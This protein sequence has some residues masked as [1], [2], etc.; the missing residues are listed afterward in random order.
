MNMKQDFL[1]IDGYTNDFV[2]EVFNRTERHQP[3]DSVEFSECIEM[4]AFELAEQ[5]VTGQVESDEDAIRIPID[6]SVKD[7]LK[8]IYE[9]FEENDGR[10][11]ISYEFSEMLEE[12]LYSLGEYLVRADFNKPFCY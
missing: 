3:D 5:L 8:D 1:L 6:E 11:F 10:L 4:T 7:I 12:F 2:R 9:T